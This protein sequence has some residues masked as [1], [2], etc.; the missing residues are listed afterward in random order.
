MTK[1]ILKK[2][3]NKKSVT[4]KSKLPDLFEEYENF[5]KILNKLIEN[6]SFVDVRRKEYKTLY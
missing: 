6:G 2:S 3:D 4:G 1:V 5:R